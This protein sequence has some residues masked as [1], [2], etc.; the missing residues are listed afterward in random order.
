M[1]TPPPKAK[2]TSPPPLIRKKRKKKSKRCH[3]CAKKLSLF[4]RQ[5]RCKCTLYFCTQH[6]HAMDH[7]CSYDYKKDQ[8]EF[9][10]NTLEK[11][12]VVNKQMDRM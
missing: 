7:E 3:K 10:T 11:N 1:N 12:K 6:R 2:I 4:E 5:L 9:L 8:N